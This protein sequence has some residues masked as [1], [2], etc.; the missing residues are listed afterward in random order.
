MNRPQPWRLCL[1]TIIVFSC[2]AASALAR[3]VILTLKDGRR[4][5]GE[6]VSQ[7]PDNVVIKIANISTTFDRTMVAKIEEK[8][9]ITEQ[10][11]QRLERLAKDDLAGRYQLAQWLYEQGDVRNADLSAEQRAKADELAIKQLNWLLQDDSD[12]VQAKMLRGLVAQRIEQRRRAAETAPE[13]DDPPRR[14]DETDRDAAPA[15]RPKY[16]TEEQRNLLK[17]YEINLRDRPTVVVRPD[18][19]DKIYDNPTY[20]ADQAMADYQGVTG[21]AKFRNLPGYEQLRILFD[22]RARELYEEVVIRTEPQALKEFR[23]RINPTYVARYCGECHGPDR[24]EH[25]PIVFNRKANSEQVAY[26]NFL[27]LSRMRGGKRDLID[28]QN[29]EESRLLQFGLPRDEAAYPHPDVRKFR[30]YFTGPE[31]RRYVE[32]V[33]WI[34]SLYFPA[35]QYPI[36]YTPPRIRQDEQQE[37]AEPAEGGEA[38][39]EQAATGAE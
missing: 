27:I 11:Q 5:T 37:Q 31:D 36:D 12:H 17:I 24:A 4:I 28:R 14:A 23:T 38:V 16:L 35:P 8:L 26:T 13:R 32:M 1:V 39:G 3:E 15:E 21:K 6:L 25:P 33:E 22:L 30:Q 7:S 19:V 10:Y 18:T 29:P 9:T 34:R 2:A 20:R